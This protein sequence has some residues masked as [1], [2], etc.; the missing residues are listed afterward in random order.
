DG[1]VNG[2]QTCALTI[3]TG[4]EIRLEDRGKT[5]YGRA[6][7]QNKTQK[8]SFH[9]LL[10]IL[11]Y[12]SIVV[13]AWGTNYPLIKLALRDLEPLTFSVVRLFGGTLVVFVLLKLGRAKKVLPLKEERAALALISVLQIV[14][15]LGLASIALVYLPAGRIVALIY[16]MPFW[17]ALFDMLFFKNKPR[18]IQSLGILLSLLGLLVY[19]D[20]AVLAWNEKGVLLG[21]SITIFAALLWGIGAVLYRHYNFQTPLLNQTL[22]QLGVAALVMLF[23]AWLLEF[24]SRYQITPRIILILVWNWCL[25][26]ALA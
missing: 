16:S 8:I 3:S 20:P 17:A 26:T 12:L 13:L 15:V 21:V 25:P 9:N 18:I 1:K 2:V 23:F 22:W 24:P 4:Y 19:F 7:T 10:L 14:S 5:D 6:M 11:S